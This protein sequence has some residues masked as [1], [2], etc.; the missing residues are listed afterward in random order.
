MSSSRA[1]V[2]LVQ[3]D[4]MATHHGLGCITGGH[5]EF[6]L[7]SQLAGA[8]PER[9]YQQPCKACQTGCQGMRGCEATPVALSKCVQH[10]SASHAH[11]GTTYRLHPV[12]RSVSARRM[13]VSKFNDHGL[14]HRHGH[15]DC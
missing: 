6:E 8:I 5:C 7:L 4:C 2:R 10:C 1:F 15:S 12:T 14:S 9:G 11:Q 13:L 3:L